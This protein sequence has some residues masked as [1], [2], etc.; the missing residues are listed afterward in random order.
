LPN[1]V[2]IDPYNFELYHFKICA[3]FLRH[4]VVYVT[5]VLAVVRYVVVFVSDIYSDMDVD[6][7]VCGANFCTILHKVCCLN[8]IATVDLLELYIHPYQNV[9]ALLVYVE[10]KFL[11]CAVE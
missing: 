1:V 4:S 2:K 10:K 3:F 11:P 6:T 9:F 8:C 5:T 7:I